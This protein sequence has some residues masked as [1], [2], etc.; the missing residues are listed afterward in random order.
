M[1]PGDQPVF[2]V[3][4]LFHFVWHPCRCLL[5]KCGRQSPKLK[6]GQGEVVRQRRPISRRANASASAV[7][8]SPCPDGPRGLS[9][10][11]PDW[12]LDNAK[13]RE[14]VA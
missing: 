8:E 9:S 7:A 5:K 1:T 3:P 6:G 14:V 10:L 4:C 11:M 13:A 2:K 12:P